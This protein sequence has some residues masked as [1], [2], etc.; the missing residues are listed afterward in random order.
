M[1]VVVE[2][3][4]VFICVMKNEIPLFTEF[5]FSGTS[6]EPLSECLRGTHLLLSGTLS[7]EAFVTPYFNTVNGNLLEVSSQFEYSLRRKADAR[8][9]SLFIS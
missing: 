3:V 4:R 8:N 6:N 7:E 5:P 2:K 1:E 9:V